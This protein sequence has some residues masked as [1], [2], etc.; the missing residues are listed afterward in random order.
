MGNRIREWRDARGLTLEALADAAGVSPGYLSRM[1]T[2]GRNVSLK[3]LAKLAAALGVSERDLVGADGAQVALVGFVSAG[4]D[5]VLFAEG[6]GPFGQVAA[7]DWASARTV[8]VEVRGNSLGPLFNGWRIFYDDRRDPPTE[9][10][11]G[12]ICVIGLDDGRIVVKRL[13]PGQLPKRFN[14]LSNTEPPIY[15]ARIAW[16]ARVRE[17]RP[18]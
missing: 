5:A 9:D 10:L 4:S 8:A 15:D 1:E 7:P 2:G 12:A 14:L 6:Q 11:I 18:K 16:A 13:A 17:M 3:N